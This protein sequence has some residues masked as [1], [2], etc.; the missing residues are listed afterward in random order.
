M[1][2]LAYSLFLCSLSGGSLIY[3]FIYFYLALFRTQT[4]NEWYN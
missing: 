4:R 2:L 3:L 1:I